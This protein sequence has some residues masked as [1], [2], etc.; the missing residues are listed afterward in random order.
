MSYH[1]HY[2]L[3]DFAFAKRL[4]ALRKRAGLTQDEVAL[5]LGVT[6]KA[7]R[8]WE[9]GSNYPTE[10]NLRK[11]IELY[12]DKN[13]FSSGQELNEAR[14]LWEQILERA[15]RRGSTFDELWFATVLKES[16]ARRTTRED[17]QSHASPA[18]GEQHPPALFALQ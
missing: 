10:F 7:I 3:G 17:H 13:V 6:E 1:R 4:L 5:M 12:L 8:N 18:E 9:G 14:T 11:L 15:N 2:K 16:H